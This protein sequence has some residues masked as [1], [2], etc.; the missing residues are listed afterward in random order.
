[1][2]REDR[3][4]APGAPLWVAVV[5]AVVALAAAG[6]D[7]LLTGHRPGGPI[8]ARSG[9]ELL[10]GSGAAILGVGAA[11]LLRWALGRPPQDGER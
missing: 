7:L 3:R 2:S 4:I 11:W 9:V 1:M 8:L 10:V 6:A 5:A